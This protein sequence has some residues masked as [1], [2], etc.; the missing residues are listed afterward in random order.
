MKF[1]ICLNGSSEIVTYAILVT[2]A[3]NIQE[4]DNQ[5]SHEKFQVY[6][7]QRGNYNEWIKYIP[8]RNRKLLFLKQLRNFQCF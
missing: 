7:L 1:L 6:F 5:L 3:K 4:I 8:K 2:K